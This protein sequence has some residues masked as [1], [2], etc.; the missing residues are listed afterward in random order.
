MLI[1]DLNPPEMLKK[2]WINGLIFHF[3]PKLCSRL[4]IY[5]HA[6]V[7]VVCSW[8]MYYL[9]EYARKIHPPFVMTY[10]VWNAYYD[11]GLHLEGNTA[12]Q[13]MYL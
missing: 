11:S 6:C 12:E 10:P 5:V 3:D 4:Y 8:Y 7:C 1:K 2:C 9:P 13:K